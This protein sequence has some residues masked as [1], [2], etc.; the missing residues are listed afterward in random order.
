MRAALPALAARPHSPRLAA[1][2]IIDVLSFGAVVFAVGLTGAAFMKL[3]RAGAWPLSD[4]IWIAAFAVLSMLAWG[5]ARWR[6]Q[7]FGHWTHYVTRE[8]ALGVTPDQREQDIASWMLLLKGLVILFLI[9]TPHGLQAILVILATS[10]GISLLVRRRRRKQWAQLLAA[11]QAEAMGV[12]PDRPRLATRVRRSMATVLGWCLAGL[13]AV[14]LFPANAVRWC[15]AVVERTRPAGLF[16]L[17][18]AWRAAL[19]WIVAVVIGVAAQRI[20]PPR[21]APDAELRQAIASTDGR[22]LRHALSA[23]A[24]LEMRDAQGRTPLLQVLDASVSAARLHEATMLLDAG[25]DPKARDAAGRTALRLLLAD[26][27][28]FPE[29]RWLGPLASADV[30]A[31]R[32]AR[33]A[34]LLDAAASSGVVSRAM[35]LVALGIDVQALTPDGKTA[36]HF[37]RGA[38]MA[39]YLLGLGLSPDALDARGR[40]P[41]HRAVI[42][43]DLEAAALLGGSLP[44]KNRPDVYGHT[45][46]EDAPDTEQWKALAHWLVPLIRDY[47]PHPMDTP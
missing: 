3:A 23:G 25:A 10:G 40:T 30:I 20:W 45:A 47:E 26:P 22:Q 19:L 42:A 11:R 43:G 28:P 44:D 9:F 14:L 41:F 13:A 34:T 21:S 18:L 17:S 8:P 31:D 2:D 35:R 15:V 4:E 33:G 16:L 38:P 7:R 37:A 46:L 5:L 27:H 32:D 24:K 29:D 1:A 12:R 6:P 36:L 39:R